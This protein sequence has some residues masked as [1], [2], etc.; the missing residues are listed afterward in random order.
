MGRQWRTTQ[1]HG[2]L[3]PLSVQFPGIVC[4]KAVEDGSS[5]WAP[6]PTWELLAR[7][8]P[9]PACR[10][11]AWFGVSAQL[12][13]SSFPGSE[14]LCLAKRF[15]CLWPAEGLARPTSLSPTVVQGTMDSL[16]IP[17]LLAI[18]SHQASLLGHPLSDLCPL[19]LCAE[20]W[21]SKCWWQE[22]LTCSGDAPRADFSL[23]CCR[24]QPPACG[25]PVGRL[26]AASRL[27]A[28]RRLFLATAGSEVSGCCVFSDG[29]I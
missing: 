22:P 14:G 9:L 23:W 3:L 20:R 16:S 24:G 7:V 5:L 25:P 8:S 6:A 26:W 18:V 1:V 29:D 28:A 17:R 27:W 21:R 2:S 4:G 10:W 13:C 19:G 12:W 11:E 15:S